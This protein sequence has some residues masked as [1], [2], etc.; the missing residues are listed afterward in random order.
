MGRF[1]REGVHEKP[2]YSGELPENGW[3]GQFSDLRGVW[4]KSGVGGGCFFGGG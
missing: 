3:I 2:I 4:Q 1:L